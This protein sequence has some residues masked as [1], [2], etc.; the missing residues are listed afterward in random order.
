MKRF[1]VFPGHVFSK[2]DGDRH[3]I[4]AGDLMRLYGVN[5][6]D[7]LVVRSLTDLIG[8]KR[9]DYTELRPRYDGNYCRV[10]GA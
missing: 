10:E 7:C 8:I 1:L 6:R 3:Y 2:N 9:A 4:G 5:P